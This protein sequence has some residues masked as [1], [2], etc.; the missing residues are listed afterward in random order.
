VRPSPPPR[1][2]AR[3]WRLTRFA[4]LDFET[5]GLDLRTDA[6]ISF[7]VVPVSDGRISMSGAVHQLIAPAIPPSPRSQTIHELRPKD[8]EGAPD[9]AHAR[10]R[11]RAC[12]DG[13]FLL[14]WFAEI[15]LHFLRQTFG[16]SARNWRRRSIDVRNLAIANDGG[17]SA[18]RSER[19]Y[20][21]TETAER[22]GVPVADAHDALDDALVTA[23]LF[24]VL[25]TALGAGGE[26]S[27]KELRR[28][29]GP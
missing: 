17:S 19:G 29:G 20:S 2:T 15:E 9:L 11:L 21:L 28:M 7:G 25:A 22:L 18:M 1:G 5:T 14:L 8:L 27:L 12:L 6:V 4:A 24:L 3:S 26:A 13:R 16:G 23:Q 10:D